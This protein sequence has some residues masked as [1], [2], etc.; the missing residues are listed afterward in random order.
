MEGWVPYKRVLRGQKWGNGTGKN[1]GV[2]ETIFGMQNIGGV[3][4]K[5]RSCRGV[6]ERENTSIF[7]KHWVFKMLEEGIKVLP[8]AIRNIIIQYLFWGLINDPFG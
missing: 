2:Y 8:E 3:C 4:P 5:Q 7:Y 1:L 6:R